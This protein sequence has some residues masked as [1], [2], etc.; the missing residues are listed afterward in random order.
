MSGFYEAPSVDDKAIWD[1]WLSMHHL[2]A[3]TVADELGIFDAICGAPLSLDAIAGKLSLNRRALSATLA[4]LCALNLASRREGLYHPTGVT[5]VYLK[6]DSE[7][8]WGPL[9]SSYKDSSPVHAQLVE[10]LK[11]GDVGRKDRPVD[12]WAAGKIAPEAAQFIAKFMHAHSLSAAVGAARAGVFDGVKRLLDVGG[13][14]GVFAISAA[15]RNPGLKATVMDLDT[16][17]AASN[18]LFVSRSGVKDRVDTIAVDMFREAWPEG[19]DALFF[20]NIFHD[21]NEETNADLAKKAFGALPSG[22]RVLLHEMLMNDNEDGPLTP[23]SFSMLML[24]GTQ[25]KQYT[26]REL[27]D[28]LEGAGFAD[29]VATQTSPYYSIVSARKP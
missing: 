11:H 10:F 17:C 22:G 24:R 19:Y 16:M 12:G 4:M 21:W 13:G 1:L 23:A 8:Y 14:S 20:S 18:D 27:T 9:F 2:P 28:I 29:V 6:S 5:R 25:G 26:F 15:Q 7:Y 3:A